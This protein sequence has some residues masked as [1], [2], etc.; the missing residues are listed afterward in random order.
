MFMLF[1]TEYYQNLLDI[2]FQLL[3]YLIVDGLQIDIVLV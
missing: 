2:I 3:W 1:E